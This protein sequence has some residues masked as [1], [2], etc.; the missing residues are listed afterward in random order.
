MGRCE[1][2]G[3]EFPFAIYHNGF[4]DSAYGYCEF[5]GRTV[6]LSGWSEAANRI[7]FRVHQP[8]EDRIMPLLK[9]CPCGGRFSNIAKPRCPSCHVELSA[10]AAAEYIERNAPGTAVGWRW[11]RSWDGVYCIDI[12]GKAVSD[13]WDEE[14]LRDAY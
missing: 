13:P 12:G 10:E 6:L 2:C 9:S 4:G 11:Q 1:A 5:C 8:I 7:P 3:V 14:K